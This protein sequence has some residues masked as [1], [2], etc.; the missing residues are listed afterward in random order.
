[1]LRVCGHCWC[2]QDKRVAACEKAIRQADMGLNPQRNG[3]VLRIAL[4]EL[5]QERRQEMI[6][7]AKELSEGAK[8][9][10]RNHNALL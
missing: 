4:P 6:K 3:D 7:F 2:Q 1:M 10:L 9:A 5:T 8:I